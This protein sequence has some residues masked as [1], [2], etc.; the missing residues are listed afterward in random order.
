MSIW[1]DTKLIKS[2][3]RT[4][5]FLLKAKGFASI[6]SLS[7][8]E[9]ETLKD[10]DEF[11]EHNELGL[12]FEQLIYLAE[13]VDFPKEFWKEM[14]LAAKEMKLEDEIKKCES[15]LKQ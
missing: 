13:T 4:S 6:N 10:F 3:E 7:K 14:I 9:I 5:N 8:T 15:L 2:W 1:G 12:A 11:L